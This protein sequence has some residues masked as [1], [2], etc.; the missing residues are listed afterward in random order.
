M[1][2][3]YDFNTAGEQFNFELIP[4]G[5]I[6]TVDMAIRPGGAGEGGFLTRSKDSAS[7]H[8]SVECTVLDGSYAKR[9]IYERILIEGTTD[10]Q[11]QAAD[12]S[13]RKIRAMLESARGTKPSDSSEAATAAR[14]IN[15]WGE[16]H[17]LRFMARIG[18]EPAK[19]EYKAKNFI[20]G[21]ITPDRTDWHHVEQ[22]PKQQTANF[23]TPASTA[24]SPVT[25]ARLGWAY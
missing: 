6:V 15:S 14:R 12:I 13:R 24:V 2:N 8:L 18:L 16:L 10:G 19:G 11:K 17:G 23:T 3:G 22:A 7:E 9:K 1:S 4:E 25:I 5:T 21:I 20:A